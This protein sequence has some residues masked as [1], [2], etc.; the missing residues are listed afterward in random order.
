MP[1]FETDPATSNLEEEYIGIGVVWV[2]PI[3]NGGEG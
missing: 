1:N 2:S 3:I